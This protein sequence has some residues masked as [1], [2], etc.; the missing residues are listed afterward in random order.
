VRAFDEVVRTNIRHDLCA[1]EDLG[2]QLRCDLADLLGE[3]RMCET[4]LNEKM[5][6]LMKRIAEAQ[7]LDET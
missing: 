3:V 1:R 7:R 6:R 2:V 4:R 5:V